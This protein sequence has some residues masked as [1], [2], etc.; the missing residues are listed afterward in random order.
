[1]FFHDCKGKTRVRG[2]HSSLAVTYVFHNT[3]I[4]TSHTALLNVKE[5]EKHDSLIP[6]DKNYLILN[7]LSLLP[8]CLPLLPDLGRFYQKHAGGVAL[9]ST[10]IQKYQ[11]SHSQ[12]ESSPQACSGKP[13]HCFSHFKTSCHLL[14]Y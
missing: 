6:A 12:D 10:S 8:F 1:M 5:T 7:C 13:S 4:R 9:K 11:T 14:K 2:F 3:L